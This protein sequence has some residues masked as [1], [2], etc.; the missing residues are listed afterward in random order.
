MASQHEIDEHSNEWRPQS[1]YLIEKSAINIHQTFNPKIAF[2]AIQAKVL[3]AV[4]YKLQQMCLE[5]NYSA[6]EFHV[7]HSGELHI[8]MDS[9]EFRRLIDCESRNTTYIKKVMEELASLSA[10]QDTLTTDPQNGSIKF[11]NFFIGAEYTNSRFT[12]VLP[13][14]TVRTLVSDNKSAVIDVLTVAQSLNSKYAV[15]FNDLLEQ[16]SYREKTDDFT[17]TVTD[18]E[19]RNLLK[20]PFKMV[21]KKKV[22]TYPQPAS[23]IRIAIDPAI[24]QINEANLRFSIENYTHKK[25]DNERYWIFEVVSRKTIALHNFA[26]QNAVALDNIRKALNEFGVTPSTVAKIM[27]SIDTEQELDYVEFNID[28]VRSKKKTNTI[29]TSP[30]SLFMSIMDKN[31]EKHNEKWADLKRER[32]L[33]LTIKKS[34]HE[35]MLHQQKQE[36]AE[37]YIEEKANILLTQITKRPSDFSH[38]QEEFSQHLS[39][40]PTKTSSQMRATLEAKGLSPDL[41]SEPIFH[42][43]LSSYVKRNVDV[44]ELD[45]YLSK[46]ATR[47]EW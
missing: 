38:I 30:A 32:Q 2:T 46:H 27:T 28:I 22:Y 1:S 15:F 26:A 25:I 10:T 34:K 18:H 35:K 24:R 42:K 40:I 33:Q 4:Q 43:F 3:H 12:F 14:H 23:F 19:L 31:R 9:S 36:A 45:D 39:N 37:K 11:L 41:I 13:Q 29:T 6:A 17:I 5:L 16:W 44:K 47:I 8:S 20:I 21:G 7:K